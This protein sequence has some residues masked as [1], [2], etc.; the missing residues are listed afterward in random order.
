MKIF[1]LLLGTIAAGA[2]SL[3]N[4]WRVIQS[5]ASL[6]IPDPHW[7][8][9]SFWLGCIA[10]SCIAAAQMLY[11]GSSRRLLRTALFGCF[12]SSLKAIGLVG[13]LALRLYR[14]Y[15]ITSWQ[16]VEALFFASVSLLLFS[17]TKKHLRLVWVDVGSDGS[18]PL[19]PA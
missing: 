13:L 1:L 12:L 2:L 16:A 15:E 9:E 8:V 3:T 19:A 11:Q 17:I 4:A 14:G 7:I 6:L 10:F 18:G 5:V